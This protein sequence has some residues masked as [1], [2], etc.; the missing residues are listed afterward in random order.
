V[1]KEVVYNCIEQLDQAGLV[2][3]LYSDGEGMKLIRKP[4]KIHLENNNILH[5]IS[6]SLK[7]DDKLGNIREIFFINQL[8][9]CHRVNL[10]DKGDFI[11]D[12][13]YIFEVG[14][15]N[16]TFKQIKNEEDAY[17]AVDGIEC[18]FGKKIPLYLF[19]FLY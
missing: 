8:I 16:K 4:G 10:Y 1:S 13:K 12:G 9:Q 11:V 15:K 7:L 6:G 19:G 17:L 18:G 5:A 2:H 14:G 3:I